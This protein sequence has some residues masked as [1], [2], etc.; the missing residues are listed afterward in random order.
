VLV[1]WVLG[2]DLSDI[3]ECVGGP[4]Q[5]SAREQ[6]GHGVRNS[7]WTDMA[8]VYL[9]RD[10]PHDVVAFTVDRAYL[11]AKEHSIGHL[12]QFEHLSLYQNKLE[13]LPRSSGR[14][15]HLKN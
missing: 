15:T 2:S 4:V 8:H 13:R 10:P 3:D 11:K 12:E 1:E 5:R 6:M 7:N 9:T 14:L